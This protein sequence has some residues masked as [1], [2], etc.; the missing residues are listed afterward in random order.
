[1]DI[2]GKARDL[3]R[4]AVH[5]K[6]ILASPSDRDNYRRIWARDSVIAGMAGILT[7]DK[8]IVTGMKKS[9]NTLAYHQH[10]SGF[11]PSNVEVGRKNR[12]SYGTLAGRVDATLWY[13]VGVCLYYKYTEDKSFLDKHKHHVY[14][15]LN[16]VET[17]EFNGRHLIYTPLSG[18]WA[19][20]Y[21]LHGYLLYDNCLRLWG[22]RLFNDLYPKKVD[23]EKLKSI[24]KTIQINMW[25]D[26][27]S[28][29]KKWIYHK[30]L[31][32]EEKQS[33]MSHFRAGFQPSNY[34]NLFDT[35]GHAV[36]TLAGI[37]DK[38][39]ITPVLSHVEQIHREIDQTLLPAFW[40][41]I[42]HKDKLWKD[43]ENNYSFTFKN[44]PHHFH[45]GGI[46]PVMMGLFILAFRN[47]KDSAILD[48]MAHSYLQLLKSEDYAFY[49]YIDSK[50][51]KPGGQE[52]LCFSAAGTIF[53][54]ADKKNIPFLFPNDVK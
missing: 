23:P 28:N 26:E 4:S 48:N 10:F 49:E 38:K 9:L 12:I 41:I 52:N 30:R 13:I 53:M 33:E 14:R 40:P 29:H 17:W 51:F 20:E 25:P 5:K 31:Y 54:L 46:W 18:N 50:E 39:Y 21:P 8:V 34:Y 6:G 27:N 3:I 19:D 24:I 35:A 15:A 2:T 45:N 44:N 16:T 43:L 37:V 22:L 42:D 36:A 32:E 1:M 7:S 11:I 47:F